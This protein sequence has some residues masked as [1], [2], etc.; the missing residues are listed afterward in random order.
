ML[1]VLLV[2]ITRK[3]SSGSAYPM[4]EWGRTRKTGLG[5]ASEQDPNMGA[6]GAMGIPGPWVSWGPPCE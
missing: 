5:F 6:E 4:L 1:Q 3:P 2:N